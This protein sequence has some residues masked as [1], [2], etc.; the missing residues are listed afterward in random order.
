MDELLRLSGSSA[1]ARPKIMVRLEEDNWIIKFRSFMD[2]KDI[3]NIEYA[4]HLMAKEAKL[5]V[6][7]AKLFSSKKS[8]GYFGAKRFDRLHGKRIHMHT[9]SGLLHADHRQ[10]SL[11]YGTIMKVTLWITRDVRMCEKQFRAAVFNVLSHNRDNHAKKFSFLM[12]EKGS[13]FVSPAYDLTFSTGSSGEHCTMVMGEGKNPT[14]EYLIKLASLGDIKKTKALEI[15][16]EV[17]LA[18]SK[19]MFFAK[20]AGVSSAS[21]KRIQ[22]V[23]E[24]M[25]KTFI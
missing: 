3:G 14:L 24:W 8:A 21:Q 18:I 16:D 12:N 20:E 11:D 17:L 23:L 22:K 6:P 5:D 1:G 13:W 4:Y 2:Q 10:A 9:M 19:W 15:I 7:Y 25:K